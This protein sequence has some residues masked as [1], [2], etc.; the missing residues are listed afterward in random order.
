[1]D[2]THGFPAARTAGHPPVAPPLLDH[3]FV[4]LD[5]DAYQDVVGS[6]FL[7]EEFGRVRVKPSTD[8]VTDSRAGIQIAGENTLIELFP[9]AAAPF[10]GGSAGLALSYETPGSIQSARERLDDRGASPLHCELI[11]RPADGGTEP[12]PWYHL[13]QPELDADSPFHLTI[14]EVTPEYFTL[15]GAA[16]DGGR[17]TRRAHLNA[18]LGRPP[19]PH[20]RLRD[21]ADVT[22]RLRADRAR[23]LVATL[24]AL[25]YV[26]TGGP[27]GQQ[28]T[29]PDARIRVV[30]DEAEPEGVLAIGL[31]LNRPY[32]QRHRFG[33][34]SALT[35]D[36]WTFRPKPHPASRPGH[37]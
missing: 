4:V 9:A 21:V 30:I 32:P 36:V 27:D 7:R 2:A 19:A 24:A 8:S 33:E 10:P 20:L 23:R 5:D 1:M 28:L 6:R 17:L 37:R 22:V 31:S 26:A 29:G 3:V 12:Q 35:G 11:R 16:L 25:G 15:L 14:A 13:L 18:T 34:S